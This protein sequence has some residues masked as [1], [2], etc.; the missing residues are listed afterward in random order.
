MVLVK[1]GQ[2]AKVS[3]VTMEDVIGGNLDGVVNPNINV[4]VMFV[5]STTRVGRKKYASKRCSW[6]SK[7]LMKKACC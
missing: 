6:T 2:I 1:A 3:F 4:K 7:S 5:V